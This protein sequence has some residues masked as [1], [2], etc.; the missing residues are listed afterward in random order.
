MPMIET[1]FW[2]DATAHAAA[3][4]YV[5]LF[6]DAEILD[7]PVADEEPLIVRWRIGDQ[8]FLGLNGGPGHPPTDAASVAVLVDGQAEV[9]RLWDGLISDGGAPGRCGWLADPWGVSWQI[10][11]RQLHEL[12]ADPDPRV[13][14][15]VTEAMLQMSRLSVPD[16]ERAARSV[17]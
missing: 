13:A 11:P 10:V 7:P 4:R 9:D 5:D 15:A 12:L 3:R 1:C 16:L 2:Y 6:D 8:R 14:Q 17:G